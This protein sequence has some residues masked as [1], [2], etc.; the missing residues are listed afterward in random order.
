MKF[1][2]AAPFFNPAQIQKV[3]AVKEMLQ[4]NG[5]D[6]FSPKDDC[7]FQN[8]AG[9]DSQ[10]IFRTNCD[11]IEKC[12][13]VIAITDGRDVGTMWE[14]GFAYGIKKENIVY[15]WL[16]HDPK[17]NFNIMLAHSGDAV[18]LGYGELARILKSAQEDGE[19]A[20]HNYSGNM[21]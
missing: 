6:Y 12:D 14:S 7:L 9:V 5:L 20:S 8:D 11:E 3:E 18:A 16:D 1:Y 15:A 4:S 13:G 19:V 21:E 10:A 2:I 17:A